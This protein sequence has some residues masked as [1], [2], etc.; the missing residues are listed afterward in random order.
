MRVGRRKGIKRKGNP[1]WVRYEREERCMV[2]LGEV[3]VDV[4]CARNLFL[5]LSCSNEKDVRG[6]TDAS[7]NVEI[8]RHRP[9]FFV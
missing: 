8:F 2:D 1:L 5:C 9:S 6:N 4:A 3:V 7:E